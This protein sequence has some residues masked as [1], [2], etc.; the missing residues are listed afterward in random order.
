MHGAAWK[1]KDA[2]LEVEYP[3]LEEQLVASDRQLEQA[4]KQFTWQTPG[5][6][7]QLTGQQATH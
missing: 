5:D 2:I 7:G 3:L 1:V 6:Y 4:E